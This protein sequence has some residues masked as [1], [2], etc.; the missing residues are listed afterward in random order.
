MGGGLRIDGMAIN[1]SE[2]GV[3][4][5][6]A[7]NLAVGTE[8]EIMYRP[9]GTTKSIRT[10]GIVRRRAVFLYAVEFLNNDAAQEPTRLQFIR[11]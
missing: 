2:H 5:F 4:F 3:Y 7:T 11:P 8:I 6:A 9:H 1:I 10:H